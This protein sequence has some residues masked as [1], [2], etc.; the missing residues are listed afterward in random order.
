VT[1]A[2][3]GGKIIDGNICLQSDPVLLTDAILKYLFFLWDIVL[4]VGRENWEE[5]GINGHEVHL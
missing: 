1:R 4:N 3:K 2:G 5:R